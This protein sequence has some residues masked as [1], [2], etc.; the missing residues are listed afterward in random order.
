MFLKINCTLS[1]DA[2]IVVSNNSASVNQAFVVVDKY[3]EEKQISIEDN[4]ITFNGKSE[5]IIDNANSNVYANFENADFPRTISLEDGEVELFVDLQN[6]LNYVNKN[7]DKIV[8]KQGV[9]EK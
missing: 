7:G 2:K 4:Y 3:I 1:D 9:V 8:L 5:F 6:E